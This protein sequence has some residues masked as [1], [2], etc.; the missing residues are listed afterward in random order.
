MA[1]VF[2]ISESGSEPGVPSV[3]QSGVV[4]P[5]SWSRDGVLFHAGRDY[6][7]VNIYSL[8][9][10][11]KA[12]R[13]AGL[14]A[15]VT[16]A[17]GFNFA[18]AASRDGDRIAFASGVNVTSNLWQ[19][20]VDSSSGKSVGEPRRITEGLENRVAPFP[21]ADGNQ[22][23]YV[24][25]AAGLSEARVRTVSTGKEIRLAEA[26][27][28][29][30]PVI[31]ED[32]SQVAYY[33]GRDSLAI[34][35]VAARGGVPRQ[36]CASCGRP[37][38]WFEHGT[39]LLYDRAGPKQ[40]DLAVLDIGTGQ[41]KI[42]VQDPQ[43]QLYSPHLSP[44]GR[45]L[46]FTAV[47]DGRARRIYVASFA[48]EQPIEQKD[49][50]IVVA[51][52]NLERQPVWSPLGFLIYFLSERDGYRCVWAQKIDPATRKPVGEPFAARHFHQARYNLIDFGDTAEIGLSLAANQMFFSMR[53]IQSNIWLAERHP[54]KTP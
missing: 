43:R 11:S 50:T 39:K 38:Q 2:S 52:V 42:I 41:S 35:Q 53:E 20:A 18:P 45:L 44:D 46:C 16:V 7:G 32:G 49:W 9:F 28:A 29:G 30:S 26:S 6:E 48:G 15:A 37:I 22:I 34:Y 24:S 31:S 17:P 1:K 13:A 12:K 51:G 3:V 25:R 47:L 54:N 36:V 33:V 4:R 19:V 5:E 21:S 40:R 8:P 27:A 10:D 14:P 23:A